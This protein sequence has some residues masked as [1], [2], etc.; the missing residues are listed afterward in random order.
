MDRSPVL[1]QSAICG[2]FLIV[3]VMPETLDHIFQCMPNKGPVSNSYVGRDIP[4]LPSRL[5]YICIL[6]TGLYNRNYINLGPC[7]L[8]LLGGKLYSPLGAMLMSHFH[9]IYILCCLVIGDK[10]LPIT[11]NLIFE[12]SV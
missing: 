9:I 4:T 12:Q 8:N 2:P 11:G 7:F 3:F 6:Q 1:H 5:L 10:G